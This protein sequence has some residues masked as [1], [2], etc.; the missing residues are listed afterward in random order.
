MMTL[1]VSWMNI[2]FS[3]LSLHHDFINVGAQT[4]NSKTRLYISPLSKKS[5]RILPVALRQVSNFGRG[6]GFINI[7]AHTSLVRVKPIQ[8]HLT[9]P[10]LK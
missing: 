4:Q 7:S 8:V 9:P 3:I 6:K 10:S 2:Y 5:W 1:D